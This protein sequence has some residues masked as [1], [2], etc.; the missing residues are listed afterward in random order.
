MEQVQSS[1]REH[2]DQSNSLQRGYIE[3]LCSLQREHIEQSSLLQREPTSSLQ[4]EPIPQF[5]LFQREQSMT[6]TVPRG[7]GK[8]MDETMRHNAHSPR[9]STH[10]RNKVTITDQQLH[11]S[12]SQCV[13][14]RGTNFAAIT[15]G[16]VCDECWEQTQG[17]FASPTIEHATSLL[18]DSK[19]EDTEENIINIIMRE[20]PNTIKKDQI[21]VVPSSVKKTGITNVN[22]T[23]MKSFKNSRHISMS[24]QWSNLQMNPLLHTLMESNPS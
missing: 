9:R 3:Q 13:S 23:P 22:K 12:A 1:K 10:T 16:L 24:I 21:C 2:T 15:T 11:I 17:K 6:N 18:S 4:R 8:H 7:D 20:T 5:S 14:F 19:K